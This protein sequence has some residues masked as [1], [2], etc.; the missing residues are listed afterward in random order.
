MKILIIGL[1]SIGRKHVKAIN[2]VLPDAKIHAL[3]SKKE[4]EDLP[5]ITNI[6]DFEDIKSEAYDFA[7]ISN[8]T[9][10]HKETIARMLDFNIPLFIEK[11]VCNTLD[12]EET[13]NYAVSK[14]VLTYVACNLRFLDCMKFIKAQIS[15]NNNLRLN[16]VNVYCGSYL[17]EWRPGVNF[18]Q[19]YSANA[20][21][22]GGVHLDLIHELDYLYWFFGIPKVVFRNIKNNSSL[23]VNS[24][25]YANY[26]L[27]YGSFSANVVL[28]YY[29]RDTKR[30]FELV[31]EDETWYVDLLK[32]QIYCNDRIIFSSE[33]ILMDTYEKQIQ[34]FFDILKNKTETF[35]TI[36]DA[37]NV[38]KIC[39]EDYDTKR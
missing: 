27:D 31:F 2:L 37:F 20:E 32:N 21:L 35:N 30:S 6:Y 29:R 13:V 9:S 11:P 36:K 28:N 16:E 5:G 19:T 22:G 8:P 10:K 1:G 25:D 23:A 34:Y 26:A 3:R 12:I 18:R 38:L 17:P 14:N 15:T 33:Q 24:I 4:S 39:M 7:I